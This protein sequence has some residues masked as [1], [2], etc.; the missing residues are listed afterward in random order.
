[1]KLHK[2]I[3]IGLF[4]AFS[5]GACEGEFDKKVSLGINVVTNDDVSYN[6]QIVTVKKGASLEFQI[7]GDPDYLTYFSGEEGYKYRY[8]ERTAVDV[9]Q[10]SKTTLDFGLM[11]QY[12][13]LTN[14]EPRFYISTEFPG[15]AKDDYE[16][17]SVLVE[18]YE[19]GGWTEF[20][21]EDQFPKVSSSH[22]SF[23]ID[24]TDYLGKEVTIAIRYKSVNNSGVQP[25]L[26]CNLM[27][28]TNHLNNGL[29][30]QYSCSSFGFTPL[31][32][33]N[34]WGLSDQASANLDDPEYGSTTSNVSG[35]WNLGSI[36]SETIHFHSSNDGTGLKY[37]WLVSNPLTINSCSPDT[38]VEIKNITETVTSYSYTYEDIG[39]YTATFLATNANVDHS[40]STT[41]QFII[42]V[43]E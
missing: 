32:M 43:V 2:Q 10:I 13:Y 21:T 12:G 33:R 38:G 28:F 5:L 1:M 41:K 17:D 39:I 15:L 18:Q 27:H 19:D 31:N 20:L 36:S 24:M 25:V 29:T 26:E 6:G 40:S 11:F 16:S 7:S 23:S 3:A 30:T 14:I 9:S 35:L 22:T 42:N 8:R 37:G 4:A 34:K